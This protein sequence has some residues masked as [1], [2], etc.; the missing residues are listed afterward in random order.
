MSYCVN[1][2]VEL[3][4][5]ATACPLC[6]TKIYHPDKIKKTDSLP[7][8][9][10]VKGEIEPVKANYEF[11]ILM[12]IIL[13]TTALVCVFLNLFTI[14]I[15]RWSAYVVGICAAFWIFFIPLF[16]PH[17]TSIYINVALD[18]LMVALFLAIV[19]WLHPGNG[20]YFDIAVPIVG[21][22]TLLFEIMFFFAFH[23]KSSMLIKTVIVVT[24]VA[25]FCMVTEIVIDLHY[26]N[27]FYLR[28]SV[29]VA[30]CAFVIDVILMTIYL[31]EGLR[32]E[33]RRRMHF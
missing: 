27:Y 5:S 3:H 8:Y 1:C 29:V 23:L 19:S 2:G 9:A 14:E 13:I 15:G 25:I 22:G 31:R 16:F 10:T 32:S 11:T 33:L 6:N 12:T 21:L 26:N 24:S 28:W 7:P 30:I 18:G 17:K 4:E 20:W